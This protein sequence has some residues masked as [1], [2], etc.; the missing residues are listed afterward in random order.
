M[1]K[2][3]L[4]IS[5]FA[6]TLS[7][8][9]QCDVNGHDFGD[10]P[11]GVSPDATLGETFID[12]LLDQAYEDVLY[13]KIPTDAG[14]IIEG[15][16]GAPVDSVEIVAV[17]ITLN[18]VLMQ[19]TDMGLNYECNNGGFSDS[20]CTYY[21]GTSGCARIIGTPTMSGTF[22]LTVS[23]LGWT[24]IFGNAQN[25]SIVYDQYTLYIED[26]DGVEPV[27][28][29]NFQVEQNTPNPFSKSTEIRLWLENAT[30][31]N[32]E[33]MNLLGEVV[34][35]DRIIGSKGKNTIRLNGEDLNPGI[36]LYSVEVNGKRVTKRMMINH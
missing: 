3:L 19:L 31:I 33:V 28:S 20:P 25:Q 1:K 30:P 27:A 10:A 16:E 18:G 32:Y 23:V 17:T 2:S 11:Y 13:L 22:E 24:T 15:F 5:I 9:A 36:Y 34:R 26:P 21:G 29:Y 14:D 4:S 7:A 12:G 35:K 8:S 6:L